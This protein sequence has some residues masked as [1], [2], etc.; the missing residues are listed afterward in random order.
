M[1]LGLKKGT[2]VQS[3]PAAIQAAEQVGELI[4]AA[5][6]LKHQA[7]MAKK[8]QDAGERLLE[9]LEREPDRWKPSDAIAAIRLGA[10]IERQLVGLLPGGEQGSQKLT[11]EV[12]A[13]TV[14]Q[15][16]GLEIDNDAS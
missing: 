5:E 9:I 13:E 11:V 12:V 1:N 8:L 6:I 7:H 14:R 4:N 10:E 16:Y 3:D 15:L 2:V